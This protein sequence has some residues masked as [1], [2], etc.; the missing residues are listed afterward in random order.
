MT[1]TGEGEKKAVTTAQVN[2]RKTGGDPTKVRIK[3]PGFGQVNAGYLSLLVLV[4]QN[5]ILVLMTRWSRAQ[6]RGTMY[7]SS[8]LILT[9]EIVKMTICLLALWYE[10]VQSG[11]A[12]YF[13]MKL[14]HIVFCLE[15]VKLAVPAALFTLQNY[16]LFVSLSN[17]D[18]MMFQLLSQVKLLLAAIFS[19]WLLERYLTCVQWSSVF[20]L[21]LG[22]ILSSQG[23]QGSEKVV[24]TA[25]QNTAIGIV[26][27]VVS[28]TSS[29]FASVYFEKI[30][31][32]TP[33]SIA[34]RNIQLGIFSIVLAVFSML[35]V[36]GVPGSHFAFFDGYSSMTWVLVLFHAGGGILVAVVVKYADNILKGFA[37][38]VAIIVSGIYASLVWGF[39]PTPQFIAGS[40]VVTIGTCVYNIPD[41][42]VPIVNKIARKMPGGYRIPQPNPV[43]EDPV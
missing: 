4:V 27:C 7:K 1:R 31:K 12:H 24:D 23:Q 39:T 43:R 19:V 25:K 21:T 2:E 42:D 33:P 3:V 20:M 17:L 36:D 26:S 37:T 18:A 15:T 13:R 10:V 11:Q 22:I 38:G 14:Y 41:P 34:E 9:A 29:A 6:N 40:V 32:G 5:A 35:A 28:G 8:S 16:L 30:L